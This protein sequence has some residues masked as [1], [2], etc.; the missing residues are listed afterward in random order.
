MVDAIQHSTVDTVMDLS[1]SL[2]LSLSVFVSL[3]LSPG[4][5]GLTGIY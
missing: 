3:S 2:S 5:P 4:E 1:L